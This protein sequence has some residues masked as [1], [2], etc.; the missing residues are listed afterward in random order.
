MKKNKYS[1]SSYFFILWVVLFSI[2]NISEQYLNLSFI[3]EMYALMIFPIVFFYFRNKIIKIK[4]TDLVI[5]VTILL[6]VVSGLIGNFRY[7][8]QKWNLVLIDLLTNLKF[9]MSIAV[10]IMFFDLNK[11][12]KDQKIILIVVKSIVLMLFSMFLIDRIFNVFPNSEYRYGIKTA[13]LFYKHA[14]YFAGTL[15]FLIAI[16]TLFRNK[17]NK[18]YIYMACIM[19]IFTLRSKAIVAVAIYIILYVIVVKRNQKLK[20]WQIILISIICL[21]IAW[22]QISFYFIKLGGVSARS[23]MLFTAFKIVKDYFPI[24][25]GFATYA[26]HSAVVNYSPVYLKYGFTAIYELRNSVDGTFFDDQFWPIIL[27]QTGIIGTI[28]YI[29][30]LSYVIKK[31]LRVKNTNKYSYMVGIFLFAY[32]LVASIAE[33]A[34]NNSIAVPMA[35]LIGIIIKQ[36]NIIR[37]EKERK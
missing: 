23:V 36:S 31:I 26:S 24:G 22:S 21:A 16:L 25:T 37:I 18:W 9:F 27:G 4:K 28:S 29:I 30:L 11:L 20:K 19:L 12:K 15:I 35:M 7:E 13:V 17:K 5:V 33:S 1:I 32:L 34:F 14:T 10:S 6:F 3:D 2:Q 8:Y